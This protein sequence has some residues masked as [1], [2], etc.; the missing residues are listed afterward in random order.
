VKLETR[1]AAYEVQLPDWRHQLLSVIAHPSVAL[2]LMMVG[3]YGLMFEFASPGHGVSG[4][5]GAIC[6]LLA[7]F[8]LQ[9]LP[10][11]YAALALIL[12]G[13]GLL[14]AELL[15]P[16]FGILGAGGLIAFIAGGILLFDE[17]MPGFGVPLP[18]IVGLA[19][20]SAAVVML[21]GALA[22][23]GHRRPVVSGREVMLG[24]PGIVL[25]VFEGE[26]W[27]QVLGERWRVA[28]TEPLVPG[29]R[30]RVIG[31]RGLTLDVKADTQPN[32]QGGSP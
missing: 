13:M 2:I 19:A 11:N 24:S 14:V 15:S 1:G 25:E 27:A 9:L 20:A 8:A 3:I 28:S 31:L 5:T 32:F 10:V 17:E 18:L 21:G 22:L 6:L 7:L 29:Q 30:I 12:L 26:I 16:S 4:V 23:K